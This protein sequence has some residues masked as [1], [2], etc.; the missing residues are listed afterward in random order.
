MA[1]QSGIFKVEGTILEGF[2]QLNLPV[3]VKYV[4]MLARIV[5]NFAGQG[6]PESRKRGLWFL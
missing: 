3:S 6:L 4:E 5:C 2:R 1:K